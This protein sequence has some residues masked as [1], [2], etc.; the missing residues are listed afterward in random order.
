MKG[1]SKNLYCVYSG[2]GILVWSKGNTQFLYWFNCCTF[3]THSCPLCMWKFIQS[4]TGCTLEI[5]LTINVKLVTRDVLLWWLTCSDICLLCVDVSWPRI[6][7][8]YWLVLTTPT[9]TACFTPLSSS[10]AGSCNVKWWTALKYFLTFKGEH[11]CPRIPHWRLNLA[12]T[13]SSKE[14]FD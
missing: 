5:I 9:S 4:N 10:G 12:R 14:Y 6:S 13:K 2:W 1:V 8:R 11:R 3:G 7:A